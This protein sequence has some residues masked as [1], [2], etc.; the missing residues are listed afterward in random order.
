M[1]KIILLIIFISFSA[2]SQ[3][4]LFTGTWSNENCKDCSKKYILKITM[5]QSNNKIFGTAEVISD[6]AELNSGLMEVTGHV[7]VLGEKAQITMKTKSGLSAGATL[8]VSENIIEFNKSGGSDLVPK[9][10]ILKKL[11]E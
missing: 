11:Y 2:H 5:A 9:E 1:R 7:Y 3:T 6:N 10:V 4:N 8:Y